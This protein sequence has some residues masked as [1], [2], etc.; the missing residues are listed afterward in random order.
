LLA[1]PTSVQSGLK[2]YK[3]CGSRCRCKLSFALKYIYGYLWLSGGENKPKS[4]GKRRKFVVQVQSRYIVYPVAHRV[5]CIYR[6]YQPKENLWKFGDSASHFRQNIRRLPA[7]SAAVFCGMFI[8]RRNRT[9]HPSRSRRPY[10][11]SDDETRRT[12]GRR[13]SLTGDDGT[14]NMFSHTN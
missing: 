2:Y 10:R 4:H 8:D 12:T 13:D 6:A 9:E 5:C 3:V 14:S 1:E 11:R 7:V